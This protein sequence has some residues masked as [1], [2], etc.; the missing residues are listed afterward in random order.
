MFR[1]G[2]A[3]WRFLPFEN[4]SRRVGGGVALVAAWGAVV[5]SQKEPPK[6][7]DVITSDFLAE[8]ITPIN[9]L[10]ERADAVPTKME[11][12]IMKVQSDLVNELQKIEAQHS[13]AKFRVD[14]WDREEGGGGVACVLQDGQVFEKAG[15]NISVVQGPLPAAALHHMKARG[16]DFGKPPFGFKAMGISS[17]IHP[18]NPNVPTVHFNYRYF[19]VTDARGRLTWWFGG[20]SD[21]TPYYLNKCDDY[22]HIKHRGFSRGVGGIF[23]DDLADRYEAILMS[24]PLNAR[25]Y[26][27]YQPEAGSEEEALLE[28]L[29]KPVSWMSSRYSPRFKQLV[30]LDDD[31]VFKLL[32]Q[33]IDQRGDMLLEAFANEYSKED[34]KRLFLDVV[35]ACHKDTLE[36]INQLKSDEALSTRSTSK[37]TSHMSSPMAM[38]ATFRQSGGTDER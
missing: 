14:R 3:A 10:K 36:A 5:H 4:M 28:I 24:L 12:M 37:V 23:F 6:P 2:R 17:V 27:E 8:P 18:R 9:E 31:G 16:K 26:Y 7:K 25:W 15:V 19:E 21:L 11:L 29:K 20:G 22:F 35:L 32:C 33:S 38:K 1:A 34:E 13:D 30:Q